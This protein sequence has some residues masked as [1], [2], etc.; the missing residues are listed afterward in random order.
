MA[1]GAERGEVVRS[2]VG[3]ARVVGRP[4]VSFGGV[5][6]AAELADA[7]ASLERGGPR[8]RKVAAVDIVAHIDS[9]AFTVIDLLVSRGGASS[10]TLGL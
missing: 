9:L 7:A 5:L 8:L 3:A 10:H 4:V 6:L 2:Y 1:R